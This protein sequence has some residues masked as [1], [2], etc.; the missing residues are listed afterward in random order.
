MTLGHPFRYVFKLRD[1]E[2]IIASPKEARRTL[3]RRHDDAEPELV[4]EIQVRGVWRNFWPEDIAEW[5]TEAVTQRGSILVE[6]A[7]VVS[8]LG[9]GAIVALQQLGVDVAG[10]FNRIAGEL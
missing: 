10:V 6:Y 1:G 4:W 3:D 2:T 8:L 5:T 9:A 7:L